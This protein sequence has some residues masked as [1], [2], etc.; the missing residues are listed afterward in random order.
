MPD[1][2]ATPTS[3]APTP[4]LSP[5]I[6]P[7]DPNTPAGELGNVDP[8]KLSPELQAI[9]RNMQGD[10]TRKSQQLAEER[11]TWESERARYKDVED[12]FKTLEQQVGQY[13]KQLNGWQQWTP[14]LQRVS[15]PGMMERVEAALKGEE[16][17]PQGQAKT[18][19]QIAERLLE[20]V[21]D[22]DYINGAMLNRGMQQL[23]ASIRQEVEGNYQKRLEE[24]ATPVIQQLMSWVQNYQQLAEQLFGLRLQHEYGLNPQADRRFDADKVIQTA[25]QYNLTDLLA[26]YQL[27]Y[28][29]S[30]AER[31]INEERERAKVERER[32]IQE[33]VER[34]KR[35]AL[36]IQN[37]NTP[38]FL[39]ADAV[40]LPTFKK[41]NPVG[42]KGAEAELA[43]R[44]RERG[45]RLG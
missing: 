40:H 44:L 2:V 14:F 36:L 18:A 8:N 7:Q 33:A 35:E 43:Q 1:P 26:A 19:E 20:G 24:Y 21:G 31:L 4:A 12:K 22:D 45:L 42:Y 34:A 5:T 3:G 30:D 27:A 38:G 13:Q 11:K 9:Y 10:Y 37:N 6:L 28:G 17:K 16:P 15:Q 41:D 29:R 23:K 39:P 32:E 25:K